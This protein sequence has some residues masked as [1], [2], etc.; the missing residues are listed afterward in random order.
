MRKQIAECGAEWAPLAKSWI[1]ES[2]RVQWSKGPPAPFHHGTSR[3]TPPQQDWLAEELQRCLGTGAW[4]YTNRATHVS[5][6]FIVEH[7]KKLRLVFN[8][9]H[10]NDNCRKYSVR[11]EPLSAMRRDSAKDDWMWSIDL[12]D[13]YHHMGLHE[14]DVHYFTFVV[15]IHGVVQSGYTSYTSVTPVTPVLGVTLSV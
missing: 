7:S 4:R 5:R 2:V 13:A 6:A 8:L 12:T 9:R 1:R 11:Y 3:F 10:I 15:E 14:D